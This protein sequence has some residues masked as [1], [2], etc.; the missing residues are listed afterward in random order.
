AVGHRLLEPA[1][2][3][4][5]LDQVARARERVLAQRQAAVE[6][7][8]LVVQ[9]DPGSLG[10]GELAAVNL[11]LADEH[12]Q[13]R[14]LPGPIR[15]G[16][17]QAVAALDGERDAFEQQRAGELLAQVGSGDDRHALSVC[18]CS[19]WTSAAL[20]PAPARTTSVAARPVSLLAGP[21]RRATVPA[22]RRSSTPTSSCARARRWWPRPAPEMTP[23]G[24]RASGTACSCS[25]RRSGR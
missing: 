20:R 15:T 4:L 19:R 12:P 11:A 7:G 24:S 23:P 13:E 14:R 1:E 18:G 17:R 16:E 5:G 3:L 22:A 21:T 8:P 9:G 10:E 25:T 6:R 2:L